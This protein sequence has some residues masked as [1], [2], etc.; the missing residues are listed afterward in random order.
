MASDMETTDSEEVSLTVPV[1]ERQTLDGCGSWTPRAFKS[2][3]K[4]D[5]YLYRV[6]V[7]EDLGPEFMPLERTEPTRNGGTG[8][9]KLGPGEIKPV[10]RGPGGGDAHL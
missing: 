9:I 10:K 3:E 4:G 5:D 8:E 6:G 1:K 2:N 7:R